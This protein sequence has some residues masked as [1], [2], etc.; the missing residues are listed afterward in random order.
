M[1]FG[2]NLKMLRISREMTQ[3]EFAKKLGVAQV[4]VSSWERGVREP[5]FEAC[6]LIAD[7]LNI[8][9]SAVM[10]PNEAQ[11]DD[12]YVAYVA[13]FLQ[14][15]P[16]HRL[17]FDRSTRMSPQEMDAVLSVVDA[18]TKGRDRNDP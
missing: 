3:A 13:N 15:S 12:R 10:T 1:T 18:I 9:L 16:K 14:N 4:T 17:L 7:T 6:E 5:N 11:A 2:E 8:P